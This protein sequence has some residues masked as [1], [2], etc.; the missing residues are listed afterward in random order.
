M[1]GGAPNV[2]N[3]HEICFP[4]RKYLAGL[5]AGGANLTAP[6][7][8]RQGN[9]MGKSDRK[10]LRKTFLKWQCRIRQVAMREDGGRPCPGMRPRL[11]DE[12]GAELTPELTVLLL[13]KEPTETTAFF[14]FQ[15]MKSA[16]PR[17][18]Y[19]KAL[20]LLQADYYQTPEAFSD[21]LLATLPRNAP[22]AET[23][24][25]A[26]HCV[27]DFAQ[28]YKAFRVPCT[29]TVLEANDA[30]RAPA[31][32]HNRVFNPQLPDTVH[33]LAFDPNWASAEAAP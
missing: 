26:R 16:D 20:K 12:D 19:E 9:G 8:P 24:I 31:L 27:L 3:R 10:A 13:P 7:A 29:V 15:V 22:L 4:I 23:L 28:G 11:V 2:V 18:S 6:P 21:R 30:G 32:W 33:V 25:T 17:E 1:L 14:R 5:A